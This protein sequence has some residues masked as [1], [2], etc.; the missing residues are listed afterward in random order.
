MKAGTTIPAAGYLIDIVNEPL[1][2]K[3]MNTHFSKLGGGL[4]QPNST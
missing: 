1:I 4:K 3:K 2:E